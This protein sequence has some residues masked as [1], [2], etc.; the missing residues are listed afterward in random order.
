MHMC[1]FIFK[2]VLDDGV[3]GILEKQMDG[4][5]KNKDNKGWLSQSSSASTT[6]AGRK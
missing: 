1:T 6:G 5:K 4:I 2:H 3:D